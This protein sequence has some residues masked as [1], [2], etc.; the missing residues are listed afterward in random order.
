MKVTSKKFVFPIYSEQNQRV[1]KHL[2]TT[3]ERAFFSGGSRPLPLPSARKKQEF[4][5]KVFVIFS[6]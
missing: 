6:G 4:F 1:K 5:L 2:S 3:D